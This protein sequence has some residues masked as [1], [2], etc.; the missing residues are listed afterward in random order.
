LE[1]TPLGKVLR[2]KKI[3]PT[4]LARELEVEYLTVYRWQTG[5][6]SPTDRNKIALSRFLGVGIEELFYGGNGI[7]E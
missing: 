2:D 1:L 4:S 7:G 5:K 6:A 3:K